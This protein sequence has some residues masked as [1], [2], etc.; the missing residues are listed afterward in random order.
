MRIMQIFRRQDVAYRLA[1]MASHW[2]RGGDEFS[3]SAISFGRNLEMQIGGRWVSFSDLADLL[4]RPDYM[5]VATSEYMANQLHA[6]I[7]VP[8]E[9]LE[10]YCEDWDAAGPNDKLLQRLRNTEWYQFARVVRNATAHNLL[11]DL[12]R[13]KKLLPIVWHGIRIDEDSDGKP[14]SDLLG[15]LP[16]LELFLAMY[17]FARALPELPT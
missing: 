1:I 13:T 16:A 8:Y 10:D 6:L 4:E 15:H 11:V 14:I 7:R 3:P 17:D 9:V 12:R 5:L 2:L